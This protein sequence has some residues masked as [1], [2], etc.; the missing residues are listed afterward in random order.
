MSFLILSE[1]Y[2]GCLNLPTKKYG[3]ARLFR[4]RANKSCTTAWIASYNVGSGN[5][6]VIS[7][8]IYPQHLARLR[9]ARA[10]AALFHNLRLLGI[11]GD[12][13]LRPRIS[14]LSVLNKIWL[15][16]TSCEVQAARMRVRLLARLDVYGS[17]TRLINDI[18]LFIPYIG[19]GGNWQHLTH[20][21]P[22]FNQ[23]I[24]WS[25]S[26]ASTRNVSMIMGH[27]NW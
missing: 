10:T 1:T 19:K 5:F 23:S 3:W 18:T 25:C 11:S 16:F 14:A 26:S 2:F 20:N 15:T 6:R 12:L 22:T 27:Q 4:W 7:A 13:G 21:F 24:L 17:Y 9:Q 8:L